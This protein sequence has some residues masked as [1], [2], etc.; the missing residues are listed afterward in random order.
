[1]AR[2][3]LEIQRDSGRQERVKPGTVQY[4]L[5]GTL[6]GETL[7]PRRGRSKLTEL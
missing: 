3:P 5:K 2:N 1:M 7:W 4:M 6:A